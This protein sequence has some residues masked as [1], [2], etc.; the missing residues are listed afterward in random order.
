MTAT[1]H[2]LIGT[3]IAA[4]IGN[5]ALAIPIAIVS[6]VVADTIPHWDTA[7]N[8][9]KKTFKKMFTDSFLDVALGFVLSYLLI[10]LF[11]PKTNLSYAFI[12]IIA[13]QLLDWV[14][15]LYY[16]FHLKAFKW[17]YSFQKMFNNDL[18]LPWGLITQITLIFGLVALAKIY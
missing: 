7:T 12:I 4:K 16:F 11:F 5:P 6:H 3:I 18:D 1:S 2:A 15:S 8:R 17:A 9:S 10:I 13:S 14:T